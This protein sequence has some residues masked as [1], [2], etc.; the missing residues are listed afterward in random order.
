VPDRAQQD[1]IARQFLDVGK[2]DVILGGGEDW[3]LPA[4]S[5][6]AYPDK[7]AEDPTEASKGTKGDLI[8][9]AKQK[10]YRYVSTAAQLASAPDGK[11]LGLFANEEM[12]QQREEGKGDVYAPVVGLATMTSKALRTLSK[13]KDGFFLF[14]EEEA[15][16][17]FSHEN[18]GTRMLQAMGELEKAVAVAKAYV[19]EHPDTLLVV[20]GDHECGG[21][22]VE[23]TATTDESGDAISKEDGPFPVAGSDRKFNLDW[24]TTSH[25]GVDLPVT[26]TGPYATQFTGKHPNTYVHQVLSKIL[27]R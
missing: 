7:P 18:N 6:G 13:D 10:G 26:A 23:D 11:L 1:E 16:D 8:A 2:P 27:T 21:L 19:A 12:F 17:E 3:W 9:R 24:T 20:T 5:Q 15:V 22:T 25:T 4:G 14:V